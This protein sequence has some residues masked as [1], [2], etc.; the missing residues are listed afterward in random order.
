MEVVIATVQPVA[1][2]VDVKETATDQFA[3]T[4][5][6]AVQAAD[7]ISG[8]IGLISRDQLADQV[9]RYSGGRVQLDP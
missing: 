1:V 6:G 3:L 2:A 4:G 7:D 9:R 8:A 5:T